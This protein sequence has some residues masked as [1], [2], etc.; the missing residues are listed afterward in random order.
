MKDM[1]STLNSLTVNS[2]TIKNL[3][4]NGSSIRSLRIFDER[5]RVASALGALLAPP[6]YNPALAHTIVTSSLPGLTALAF[7]LEDAILDEALPQA[8]LELCRTLAAIK[9]KITPQT[10]LPMLFV[11]VRTPQHLQHIQQLLGDFQ[12]LL[13]GYILPKFDLSNSAAYIDLIRQSN[14]GRHKPIYFMPILES[15]MLAELGSRRPALQQLKDELD[16][17]QK[18]I[19]N[20]RVGCNDFCS[21]FGLRRGVHQNIYQI[22]VIRDILADIVN[23]FSG[24]YVLSGPVWE[25]FGEDLQGAWAEGLRQELALDRLNG[26]IGKTAVHPAQLPIIYDSLKVSRADYEDALGLLDWLPSTLGVAKSAD[27]SRMNELKCHT[28]WALRTAILAEIYGVV[29]D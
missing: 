18:Y 1:E 27:G 14:V 11:R 26:F 17:V 16:R 7:C 10:N 29:E 8:E 3:N 2:L 9:T 6:P 22:S 13:C 24:E 28:N 20:V 5:T 4:K 12:E 15:Q 25:Y 21:L 19:L 23:I